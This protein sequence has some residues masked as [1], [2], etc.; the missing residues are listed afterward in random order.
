MYQ[1]RRIIDTFILLQ[2]L[3]AMSTAYRASWDLRCPF[4]VEKANQAAIENQEK[5]KRAGLKDGKDAVAQAVNRRRRIWF[6]IAGRG[7][8]GISGGYPG[9]HHL[10]G[11]QRRQ[12]HGPVRL[13]V[14]LLEFKLSCVDTSQTETMLTA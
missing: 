9:D 3:S 2:P 8:T 13:L 12:N 10:M 4:L 11:P 14:P 7:R 5:F 1:F 6:R